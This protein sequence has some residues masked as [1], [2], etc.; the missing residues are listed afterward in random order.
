MKLLLPNSFWVECSVSESFTEKN[1]IDNHFSLWNMEWDIRSVTSL[2]HCMVI[3]N[4]CWCS[5]SWIDNLELVFSWFQFLMSD[6]TRLSFLPAR[7]NL[8]SYL[9]WFSYWQYTHSSFLLN[10]SFFHFQLALSLKR[11]TGHPFSLSFTT[12]FQMRYPSIYKKCSTLHFHHFWV[13]S[14]NVKNVCSVWICCATIAFCFRLPIPTTICP[15]T[16]F[17][18][19]YQLSRTYEHWITTSSCVHVHHMMQK[20]GEFSFYYLRNHVG[21]LQASTAGSYLPPLPTHSKPCLQCL[22][23]KI[24]T[25]RASTISTHMPQALASITSLNLLAFYTPLPLIV[26]SPSLHSGQNNQA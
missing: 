14:D 9:F 20:L 11:K 4:I 25:T 13:S 2:L 26:P 15:M 3:G 6:N 7:E 19:A 12:I 17:L 23:L 21:H 8:V 18:L 24:P 5:C 16:E 10:T 1:N 22:S